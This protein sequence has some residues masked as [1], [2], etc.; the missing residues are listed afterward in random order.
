MLNVLTLLSV[1]SMLFV[2]YVC[3][4]SVSGAS[5]SCVYLMRP[6]CVCSY[7]V[8]VRLWCVYLL[9]LSPASVSGA[10]I[11]CVYLLRPSLVRLSPASISCV[12]PCASIPCVYLVRLSV[13]RLCCCVLLI[14]PPYTPLNMLNVLTPL[15]VS[16]VCLAR[17][18]R[19]AHITPRA[20][21]AFHP[22]RAFDSY[23]PLSNSSGSIPSKCLPLHALRR[24]KINF[25][26]LMGKAPTGSKCLTRFNSF[27]VFGVYGVFKGVRSVRGFPL[28]CIAVHITP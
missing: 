26:K 17:L 23:N 9:R 11:S 16:C 20:I 7:P 14:R 12:Q 5:I 10:S 25:F 2:S 18:V 15:S 1:S 3:V 6:V 8:C 27:E 22:F 13:S 28:I 24:V 21:Q 19:L 4:A